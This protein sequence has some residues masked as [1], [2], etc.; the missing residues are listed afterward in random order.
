[1]LPQATNKLLPQETNK[2]LERCSHRFYYDFT[3]I[4]IILLEHH[5]FYYQG[6][7]V[8]LKVTCYLSR[9]LIKPTQYKTYEE[10]LI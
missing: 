8:T 1:M 9:V 3:R 5:K 4:V 6:I 2:L 7:K 10:Q